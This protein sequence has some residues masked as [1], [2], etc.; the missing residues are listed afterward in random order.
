MAHM[1]TPPTTD[2]LIG[3]ILKAK[4]N[5]LKAIHPSKDYVSYMTNSFKDLNT[6]QGR[7]KI[8]MVWNFRNTEVELIEKFERLPEL[9]K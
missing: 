8:M 9:I 5:I 2:Q 1:Q 4:S 7:K 6:E 3:R